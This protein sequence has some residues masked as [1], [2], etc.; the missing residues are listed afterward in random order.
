[1]K[2]TKITIKDGRFPGDVMMLL[3]DSDIYD[4]SCSKEASVF[5][6]DKDGG[7]F[8]KESSAGSLEKE[9]LLTSFFHSKGLSAE[10]LYYGTHGNKDYMITRRIAGEDCTHK[11][12]L[13]DPGK[14]CDLWA[15][16]L[17]SLHET[18]PS[19]CPV[20]DRI[21][22]YKAAVKEGFGGEFYEPDLFSGLW[23]FGSAEEAIDVAREGLEALRPEALIHGDYCFP[24]VILDNWRFSGYIDMGNGGVGDRHIDLL[25]GIWT[26]KYN[27]G[28]V[29]YTDRFMDAYGREAIDPEKL[30]MVAAMEIVGR[31]L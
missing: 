13:G 6:A 23:E 30:R 22:T 20:R 12:Y 4:S 16:L 17:R 28:T 11:M 21:D 10:V 19:G 1:M 2:R 29:K 26:L 24:N 3:R 31:S 8:L 18:D 15:E 5:F 25:W 9:A 7:L 14:L 27:L